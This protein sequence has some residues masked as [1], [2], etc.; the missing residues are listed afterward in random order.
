MTTNDVKIYFVLHS[1]HIVSDMQS[2]SL[3]DRKRVFFV[4]TDRKSLREIPS[5][6]ILHQ[7]VYVNYIT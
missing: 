5:S 1:K 2:I 4:T 3:I 6:L 7:I